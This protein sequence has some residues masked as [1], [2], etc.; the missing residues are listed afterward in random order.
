M[1]SITGLRLIL[2]FAGLLFLLALA[3]WETLRSRRTRDRLGAGRWSDSEPALGE[4]PEEPI[5]LGGPVP[6]GQ[7]NERREA[8]EPRL[9]AAADEPILA[10]APQPAELSRVHLHADEPVML[11]EPPG[12]EAPA[13]T[14]QAAVT[15]EAVQAAVSTDEAQAT[16]HAAASRE[17]VPQ[18]SAGAAAAALEP[19]QAP[20]APSAPISV[21]G[22]QA[23]TVVVDWPP[24]GERQIVSVRLVGRHERL[25]G[26]T[27]RQAMAAFGFVH[28]RYRIFHQP[29][30]DGRALLSCASLS[31]PGYFDLATMDFQ[32]LAGLSLFT[33]LPGPLPPEQ[34]LGHLLDTAEELAERLQAQLQDDQGQPLDAAALAAVREQIAALPEES[35]EPALSTSVE[36]AA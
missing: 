24:D 16:H 34:A 6:L 21:P 5:E 8:H 25:L 23:A 31:K 15:H 19:S 17:P 11:P 10:T 7:D 33:V 22:T 2:L 14:H 35:M 26:R 32:R 30:N 28:G 9:D 1:A 29:L 20:S 4:L 3:G 12:L 36:P 13:A 27:V 18:E